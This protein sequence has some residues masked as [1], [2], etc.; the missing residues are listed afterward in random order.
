MAAFANGRRR[1]VGGRL[2]SRLA[3]IVTAGAIAGD[4]A[5]VESCRGPACGAVAILADIVRCD[6]VGRFTRR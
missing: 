3:A 1:Q 6:M 5:V 4:T 2:T